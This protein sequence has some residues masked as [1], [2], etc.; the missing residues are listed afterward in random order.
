MIGAALRQAG[1]E[2]EFDPHPERLQRMLQG[3]GRDGRPPDVV[4]SEMRL[5]AASGFRLVREVRAQFPA[6]RVLFLSP[7]GGAGDAPQLERGE[8]VLEKPFT[9][10]DLTAAV[11]R[12]LLQPG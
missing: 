7:A 2:V 10:A 6:L 8:A 9:A 12:L 4:L 1:Y 11:R 5:H 3:G